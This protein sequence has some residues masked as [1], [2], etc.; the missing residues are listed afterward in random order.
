[1]REAAY[2]RGSDE[3]D[4]L[5]AEPTFRDFVCMY[6]GEGFKRDRNRV[7]LANSDPKVVRLA[8]HWIRRFS[9]NAVSI[10]SNTMPT[11]IHYTS[12]LS[13]ASNSTSTRS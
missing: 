12:S 13:G 5:C 7:A 4:E 6:I 11:R 10:G 2:R 9:E 1:L 3:Y 8:D